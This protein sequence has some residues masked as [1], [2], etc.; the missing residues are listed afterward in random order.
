M[1]LPIST[2]AQKAEAN[3]QIEAADALNHK[4]GQDVEVSGGNATRKARLILVSPN[5]TRWSVLVGNT[6]TLSATSI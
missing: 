3:R 6:G 1:K 2:N 4:R 5:G